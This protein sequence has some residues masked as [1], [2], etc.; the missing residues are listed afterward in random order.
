[1][2]DDPHR[3]KAQP[4]STPEDERSEPQEPADRPDTAAQSSQNSDKSPPAQRPGGFA[5]IPSLTGLNPL[6]GLS[7]ASEASAQEPPELILVTGLSGSGKST[8]IRALEDVGYFCID[9]LPVPLL[10]KLVNLAAGGGSLQA[11]AFVIDTRSRE[12]LAEAGPMI[13]RLADEGIP[14]RIIFLEAHEDV[15][16]RRFSET[17]RLHP[18]AQFSE[19]SEGQQALTIRDSIRYEREQLEPLRHRADEVIDTSNHTVHTLK[20]LIEE[21][22]SGEKGA[23]LQITVL[24]FGFKYGL[25]LECD[26]V[27]DLRFLP[28]PYFIDELRPQT[29]LDA[30]VREYVLSFAQTSRF[31]ALFQEM[32][33]F[34]LPMYQL[35]GKSYLTI[36][37][38]CTGG[39]HRSVALTEQLTQSLRTRGWQAQ[40]RHRDVKK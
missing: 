26:L 19:P 32:A 11:L 30:P 37:I 23:E 33:D 36:G 4:S 17:R 3:A 21:D 40:P 5:R 24:S 12:F 25:P 7:E 9:N 39:R 16:V 1:M 13:D 31:I 15:L 29:G 10:P 2:T 14:M 35:E 28:N 6:S 18:M 20:A 34:M 38:G 22:L 8:A 27:F